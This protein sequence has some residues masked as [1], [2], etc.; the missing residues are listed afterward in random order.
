[1]LDFKV[2][3]EKCNGCKLCASDC[4]V[5]IINNKT[6]F[7]EI[8][9]GKEENCLECQHCLA[10]CPHGAI[11]ILGKKPEDSIPIESKQPETEE[12][13]NLMRT[14]RS[15]RKFKA[16]E[17]EKET[18]YSL[19]QSATYAPTA[20]NENSVQFTVV[21]NRED[22]NKFREMAYNAVK[23][24][25]EE[26]K[27]LDKDAHVGNFQNLW[28]TKNI[29]VVFRNAPH[30]VITTAPKNGSTPLTDSVIAMTYFELLANS[31]GIGTL[32]NG[33]FHTMSKYISQEQLSAIGIPE[34]H[35]ITSIL[36]FGKSAV[37]YARSI[38][39]D[40]NI[41]VVKL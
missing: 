10:I 22:M 3:K 39:N 7:P 1:M 31:N 23:I 40:G 2:D 21:D 27:L 38:Q 15:V 6:E 36:S 26:G 35:V 13:S 32:W 41:N 29:D 20:K 4:P 19:L 34:D 18:I 8:K 16:D 28:E 14:R 33:F 37:K 11:S 25:R 9:E 5:L 30:L 24:A 17:I 12:L